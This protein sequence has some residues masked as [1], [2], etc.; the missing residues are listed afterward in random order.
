MRYQKGHLSKK[1]GAWHARYYGMCHKDGEPS[2]REKSR[3]LGRIDE[4]PRQRDIQPVFDDFMAEI[5]RMYGGEGAATP[6][7][8]YF[9]EQTYLKSDAVK[10]LAQSTVDGYKNI[11]ETH[12]KD[13]LRT[14]TWADSVRWR[15]AA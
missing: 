9:I 6:S 3:T 5:N 11:F 4:Y 8:S 2:W 13:A 10:E 14:E 7:L 15:P 12:F 1:N